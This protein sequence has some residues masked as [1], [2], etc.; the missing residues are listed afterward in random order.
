LN[1]REQ[2]AFAHTY[3]AETGAG[4][5]ER[6]SVQGLAPLGLFLEVLGVEIRSPVCVLLSGKNPFPW[7]VTVKYRGLTVTRQ[8]DRT[9]IVFPD[10]SSHSLND[11]IEAVVSVE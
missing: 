7:P 8:S 6:N 1:L 3:H 5:G 4:S 2:R 9:E 11:P 10:G